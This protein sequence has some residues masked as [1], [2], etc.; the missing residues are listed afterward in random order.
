MARG[1]KPSGA[2]TGQTAVFSTRMT[3]AL[4]KMI[5]KSAKKN[6][7]SLTQEVEDRL[8][9][10]FETEKWIKETYG[11]PRT[12]AFLRLLTLVT[13]PEFYEVEEAS[14][15][16]KPVRRHWLDDRFHYDLVARAIQSILKLVR[17]E[18]RRRYRSKRKS[19]SGKVIT[20]DTLGTFVAQA[21]L[22]S[23]RNADRDSW[24]VESRIRDDLDTLIDRIPNDVEG[25][26]RAL[27]NEI[28]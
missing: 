24:N 3:P 25:I 20:A 19:L 11:D 5:E 17:P 16:G 28:Q 6:R 1:R 15:T 13:S 10:S 2:Y 22:L 7:R 8:R 23:I 27:E 4:R 26:V 14:E 21:V 18:R 12:Y 9:K